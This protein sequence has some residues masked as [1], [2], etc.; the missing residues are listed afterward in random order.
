M[1]NGALES[2]TGSSPN[3]VDFL[4]YKV[5]S[6]LLWLTNGSTKGKINWLITKKQK[7]KNI[8]IRFVF[9]NSNNQK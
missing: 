6:K 7:M 1:K 5:S 4:S 3:L 8:W 2:V 9:S